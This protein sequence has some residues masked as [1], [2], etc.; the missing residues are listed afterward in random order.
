MALYISDFCQRGKEESIFIHVSGGANNMRR[1][2][3]PYAQPRTVKRC[4][5]LNE[6]KNEDS[7]ISLL[8]DNI[9]THVQFTAVVSTTVALLFCA[10][11]VA[12]RLVSLYQLDTLS[13]Y[14]YVLLISDIIDF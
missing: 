4:R 3:E 14:Y 13:Y 5:L 7:K 11:A 6:D 8:H 10:T 12:V 1:K 2:G 9:D